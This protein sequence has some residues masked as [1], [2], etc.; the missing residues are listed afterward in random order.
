ME[1]E[2]QAMT[3]GTCELMWLWILPYEL[4]FIYKGPM[5]LH[6]DSTSAREIA[7]N[8]EYHSR[9]KHFEVDVH[10]VREKIES[11]DIPVKHIHIDDQLV[12]FLIKAVSRGKLSYTLS[13]LGIVDILLR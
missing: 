6:F 4:G 2:Y 9:T 1:I 12:D 8:P 11:T 10:F 3:L 7:I 5:V 13:K